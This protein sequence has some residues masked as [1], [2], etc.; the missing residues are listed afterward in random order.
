MDNTSDIATKYR[1]IYALLRMS[2]G[3]QDPGKKKVGTAQSSNNPRLGISG[4]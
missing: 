3:D 4:I 2:S 1:L